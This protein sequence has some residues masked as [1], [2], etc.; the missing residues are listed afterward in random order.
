MFILLN[1][2]EMSPSKL[3]KLI[4]VLFLIVIVLTIILKKDESCHTSRNGIIQEMS[5]KYQT[6]SALFVGKTSGYKITHYTKGTWK[7]FQYIV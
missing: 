3:A 4:L 7:T 1:M 5:P 2:N 6:T